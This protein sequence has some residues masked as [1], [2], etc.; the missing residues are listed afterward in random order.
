VIIDCCA[1]VLVGI[2]GVPL[3]QVRMTF[4]MARQILVEMV[5]SFGVAPSRF[6]GDDRLDRKRFSQ[7]TQAVREAGFNWETPI[8]VKSGQHFALPTNR[9]SPRSPPI[10]CCRSRM[11]A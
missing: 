11:D 9:S 10:C 7:L 4:A 1:L 3:L 6:S 2:E 5:R 8:P